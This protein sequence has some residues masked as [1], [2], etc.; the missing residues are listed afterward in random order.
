MI[1]MSAVP[2]QEGTIPSPPAA[3]LGQLLIERGLLSEE[4]LASALARQAETQAPLGEVLVELGFVPAAMIGQALAT[5]HG[6]LLKTEYGFATG[7]AKEPSPASATPPP[8]SEPAPAGPLRRAPAEHA[9]PPLRVVQAEQET[10]HPAVDAEPHANVRRE[11]ERE[12]DAALA[13]ADEAS[14]HAREVELARTE[15][16]E[17]NERL[18]A[19][20]A[21]QTQRR[22]ELEVELARMREHA[23]QAVEQAAEPPELSHLAFVGSP[24]GYTLVECAGPPPPVDTIVELPEESGVCGRHRVLRVTQAPMPGIKAPCVYLLPLG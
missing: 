8:T 2:D 13:R 14:H 3:P 24:A 1:E 10:L 12:R 9:A 17:A 22:N 11:L 19:E 15:L 21:E 6:G 5:Q 7:F 16:A 18:T 23:A 4:Q 20:L